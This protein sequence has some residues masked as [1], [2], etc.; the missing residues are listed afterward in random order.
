MPHVLR[1]FFAKR[2]ADNNDAAL[3]HA[4]DETE[5]LQRIER[6]DDNSFN[7]REKDGRTVLHL[8]AERGFEGVVLWLLGRKADPNV[9]DNFGWTALHLAAEGG[10][11]GVVRLLLDRGADPNATDHFERT[12]L[13]WTVEGVARLLVERVDQTNINKPD[14]L[15][16]TA[17]WQAAWRGRKDIVEL[18]LK[19]GAYTKSRSGVSALHAAAKNRHGTVALLLVERGAAIDTDEVAQF[20]F[21]IRVNVAIKNRVY[22]QTVLHWAAERGD[23]EVVQ[24][25][26]EKGADAAAK[27]DN[28]RTVL[29]L[30]AEGGNKEVVQL[31]LEKG[32]DAA[33][34]DDNGRTVLH[35]AANG[36][37][38]EVVQLLLK[39]GADAATKDD[40][41]RTVLHSAAKGGNKEVV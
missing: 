37:N 16:R 13:Q 36:G 19:N 20:L 17:L 18:L 30:A 15:R 33:A 1:R 21:S 27:D 39:K 7:K 26:L 35:L 4:L 25:L 32:A 3:H 29:H 9:A 38:K 8:A 41:G 34:K 22:E 5:F 6:S 31:L 10:H 23:K 28:G 11:E 12:A 14:K 2:V 24:L 40:Y